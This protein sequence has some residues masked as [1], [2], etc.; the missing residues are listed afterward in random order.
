MWLYKHATKTLTIYIHL[1]GFRQSSS[2]LLFLTLKTIVYHIGDPDVIYVERLS[3][4]S[5]IYI[6][7]GTF[8]FYR[9]FEFSSLV[10]GYFILLY[11][12]LY[13]VHVNYQLLM[14]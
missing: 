14:A 6:C 9:Y 11:Y 8:N 5:L 10:L 4:Y 12:D 3:D 1:F 2:H 13:P 7:I